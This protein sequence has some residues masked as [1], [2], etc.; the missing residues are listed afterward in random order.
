ME[1]IYG[2]FYATIIRLEIFNILYWNI[3][4]RWFDTLKLFVICLSI[5]EIENRKCWRYYI[6]VKNNKEIYIAKKKKI[7][8]SSYQNQTIRKLTC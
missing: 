8:K 7:N 6:D 3:R 4:L 1:I 2:K 5:G